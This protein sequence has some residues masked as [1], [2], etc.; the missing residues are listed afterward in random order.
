MGRTAGRSEHPMDAGPVAMLRQA[1]DKNGGTVKLSIK[2]QQDFWA[3]LMFIGFGLTAVIISR[4]Y[5]MGSAMRMGPGYFPTYLGIL[6]M[7]MGAI[8]SGI[9]LRVHG[10][11]VGRFG[12]RPLIML[13]LAFV[14]YGL[15]M[16]EVELGFVPSLLSVVV[17][18]WF[19][20]KGFEPLKLI[21]L[22]IV[23]VLGAVALFIWGLDLPYPLFWWR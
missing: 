21:G 19:A 23:L 22:S 17:F 20:E 6:M 7:V 14:A 18:A 16:E 13:C 12:W 11:K 3:G 15:L 1:P 9:A 8:I 4:D 2:N 10:D 5:P